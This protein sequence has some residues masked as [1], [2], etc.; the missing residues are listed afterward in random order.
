MSRIIFSCLISI[1][2]L[3][4]I[5]V[6]I[7]V[8]FLIYKRHINSALRDEG[9]PRPM[10]SLHSAALVICAAAVVIC[11]LTLF[12]RIGSLSDDITDLNYQLSSL[13]GQMQEIYDNLD[14]LDEQLRKENS[15]VTSASVSYGAFDPDTHTVE[16]TVTVVPKAT[17]G[18]VRLSFQ[19]W[20]YSAELADIGG[21]AY[22]GTF[23]MDIFYGCG[24]TPI[25][26]LSDDS[27][28]K[29]EQL[30][31]LNLYR[32]CYDYLPYLGADLYC[33]D[34]YANGRL[35]LE[36]SLDVLCQN[37][38]ADP[39]CRFTSVRLVTEIDG[40]VTEELDLSPYRTSADAYS[41][42][43]SYQLNKTYDLP[44]DSTLSI[45]VLAQDSLGYTHRNDVFRRT[46]NNTADLVFDGS[47]IYDADGNE[48]MSDWY[49]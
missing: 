15:L 2:I 40:K 1:A 49:E 19:F 36:G 20:P 37:A 23:S 41:K 33:E 21:G 48:M 3:L 9:T 7:G 28:Q 8:Y 25:L 5:A 31:D 13:R 35:A 46:G 16:V 22:Q 12:S 10:P 43:F 42:E 39:T 27:G 45:Y 18:S 11:M 44:K 34:R 24:S 32:P 38:E 47:T 30:E 4:T 29:T 17:A 14:G 26:V 6:S